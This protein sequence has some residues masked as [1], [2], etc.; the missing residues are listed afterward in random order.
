MTQSSELRS[1][2]L[3]K[4]WH[5]RPLRG[6]KS[7]GIHPSSPA[8]L[9]LLGS[10][11]KPSICFGR[12]ARRHLE[13]SLTCREKRHQRKR[14][15]R[16]Y[17]E[18]RSLY[19]TALVRSLEL[20]FALMLF[21]AC[22]PGAPQGGLR[23]S[24]GGRVPRSEVLALPVVDVFDKDGEDDGLSA[25]ERASA[26]KSLRRINHGRFVPLE[27]E[28]G[29]HPLIC[30]ML[31]F[32][33]AL[34]VSTAVQPMDRVGTRVHRYKPGA[35]KPWNLVFNG[36]RPGTSG[37]YPDRGGEG[38][39][40]LRA[41]RGRI[42]APDVDT[43]GPIRSFVTGAP[44]ENFIFVSDREGNIPPLGEPPLYRPHVSTL[45]AVFAVH[46]F[47]IIQYRNT[48]V[49]SG[50]IIA[51]DSSSKLLFP[52]ALFVAPLSEKI[53][54]PR[55][56]SIGLGKGVCR[57]TY[58]HRFRGHLFFGLQNNQH[59]LRVDLGVLSGSPLAKDTPP[60]R[61]LRVTPRGGWL[62][63]AFASGQGK[64]Y[65]LA[66]G[67]RKQGR[68]ARLYQSYDGVRF[69]HLELPKS[70]GEA[71]DMLLLGDDLYLL[72][73]RGLFR[74]SSKGVVVKLADAPA[75]NPFSGYNT[76]CSAQLAWLGD[77]LYAG[78]S[79]GAG[80]FRFDEDVSSTRMQ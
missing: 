76:M 4:A 58:L 54:V 49:A 50:G 77:R 30:D 6:S 42:Y 66:A 40:R 80:L 56:A 35:D 34:Y 17:H 39:T 15:R 48:L 10:S 57:T 23:G 2:F 52:G 44:T 74:R 1:R 67:Y 27:K 70:V 55:D 20:G 8:K 11:R 61:M 18:W 79:R 53:L 31:P 59:R 3:M 25:E 37:T 63:R 46:N 73:S 7:R 68:R 45:G 60:S 32:R 71:T 41:I 65:W 22:G 28:P 43:P 29:L 24:G 21:C 33:E 26:G 72:T 13:Q 36:D 38:L 47:D 51:F 75:G 64:L 16:V 5:P 9:N 78:S 12:R 69:A 19:V 14:P 62:T